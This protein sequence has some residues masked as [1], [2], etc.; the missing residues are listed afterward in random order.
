[1]KKNLNLIIGILLIGGA[2]NLLKAVDITYAVKV[3]VVS[4]SAYWTVTF[5]TPTY[6]AGSQFNIYPTSIT[7][8]NTG[9]VNE[10]FILSCS[11]SIDWTVTNSTPTTNTEFRLMGLFNSTQPTSSD[12]DVNIDTITTTAQ[13]ASATRYAGNQTG[14]NVPANAYRA[15]WISFCAPTGEP[16]GT[17]QTITITI[18]AQAT[19]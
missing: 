9:N 2:A 10:D 1:M 18:D 15:L 12:Y 8:Q 14:Y 11:N 6:N 19:P 3:Q 5:D 13:T 4:V 17:E 7:V 16:V